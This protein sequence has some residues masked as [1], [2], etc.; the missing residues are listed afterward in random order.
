MNLH[1]DNTHK[2]VTGISYLCGA[3]AIDFQAQASAPA[4]IAE[5]RDSQKTSI[6][7][8]PRGAIKELGQILN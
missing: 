7:M 2:L 3:C 5:T 4:G 8:K 1:T 6:V